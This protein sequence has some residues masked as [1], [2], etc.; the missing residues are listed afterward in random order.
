MRPFSLLF[1]VAASLGAAPALS[2]DSV[3][4]WRTVGAPQISPDGQRVVYTLEI[5]DR[6]ADTFHVNLWQVSTD[7]KDHRPLTSGKW[8]DSLPRWSPD[9]AKLA[10]VSTRA[11]KPQIFVRWMDTGTE[12]KI[13]DLETAPSALRWSPD[14]ESL[15]F[16]ARV[17]AKPAWSITMPKA[18][19]G[20]TWAEPPVVET[21]LKG[22]ADGLSGIGQRPLGFAHVFVVPATGGTPR[23]ITDGDYEHGG[24]P[25]WMPG[26]KSILVHAARRP[27]A[28]HTLFPDDIWRF[29]LD[30]GRPT[31][32]TKIDGTENS[33][34]PSPDGR[35]IAFTGF[36]DKGNSSHN[37]NLYVMNADGTGVRQL[38]KEL[39]RNLSAPLW[40]PNSRALLAIVEDSGKSHLYRVPVDGPAVALTQGNGRYATAYASGEAFTAA[41]NGQIAVTYSSPSEP[42]DVVTFAPGGPVRKLTNANASLLAARSIGKVEEINWKSFDGRAMQGWLIYPPDFNPAKKYPLFLDIH[43]GPHAM[44]GVEFN[45]QMQIFAGRGFVVFYANPRGSTGYGEEFGN[46]IH[47]NYPGDDYKDLMTGVDAVIAKG[48]IDPKKLCVTGGS[49]GGLLTAWIVTQTSRFAA[50]VSQYPVTNWI[51]QTGSSDIGLL[52]MRWMKATPWD[53]P[54]QYIAHSPVFF[55]HKVTTPTMV[56]TGEEDWRTPIG[57]SEEFYFALKARKVDSVLVRVPKEPHG[58]RGAFPSHRVAKLEHILAWMEK[59]TK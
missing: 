43:G 10:Y 36:A 57:Q 21:R 44:Y 7:G 1:L 24:E 48:F 9:G 17:T 46:V 4:D 37:A 38:A 39:D 59:Y 13:T 15:A 20:A 41:K 6:F 29:P 53:N 23:Q 11:G 54:Q 25:A 5:A 3:F 18:P 52:M 14:G 35:Y 33:P 42:K 50:A 45:Q 30:G 2:T 28:D 40:E 27:D 55:A 31:Q 8:K 22:R 56:L 26:G 58:I 51:T 49:G 16:L 19:A 12:A 32:L 34:I 47:G